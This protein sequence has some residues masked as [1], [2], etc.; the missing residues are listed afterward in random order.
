MRRIVILVLLLVGMRLVLLVGA[1]GAG[2]LPLLVFGFL[3][4]AAY[5]VGELASRAG[6]PKI[7]GYLA[8]GL[9][10]GSSAL[11][12]VPVEAVHELGPVSDL[13]IALIAFLAGAEL[14][15]SELRQR[16]IALLKLTATELAVT[17]LA[18][19]LLLTL[20]QEFVPFLQGQAL[21]VVLTFAAVFA[22]IVIIHSPAVTMALLSETRASGPVARTTLSVVLVA[23]VIVVLVFSSTLAVARAIV[24][25]DGSEAASFGIMVWEVLGSIPIGALLG[26][27]VAL[28]LRF[29]REELMLFAVLVAIF[30]LELARLLHVEVLLTLLLT[31][32]VMEN[33]APR[34]MGG[35]LRHAME[36]AAAPIF[37]VFF[38]LAGA[39]L[40]LAELLRLWPLVIPIVLVRAGAIMVGTRVGGR[41]AGVP[42]E[43]TR[44]LWMG[45]VS[46]AGVAIGLV[47][48]A[49]V[50]YPVAGGD[51]RALLLAVIAINE[52]LGPILFRR[53]LA[54]SGELV[55][56]ETA[57]PAA[58]EGQPGR[59]VVAGG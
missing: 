5:S 42:R 54:R 34:G 43:Q 59:A 51:M 44:L 16:G 48:V 12:L 27:V 57:A 45:L 37:V 17:F 36:R 40:D 2:G 28:Y 41:L 24:P 25:G 8:A 9:V 3:I 55:P 20:L 39:K 11:D 31:G 26:G 52:T 6:L 53:A 7:V 47:T 23:D 35:E 4:L 38:A 19:V 50:V 21:T 18:M 29:V 22:S 30:G 1:P 33:I 10:C 56:G 15:W 13:A 46:Q 49:G 14:E 58:A 32:F